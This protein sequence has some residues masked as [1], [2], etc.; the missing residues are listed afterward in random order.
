MSRWNLIWPVALL[1]LLPLAAA[2]Y[3]YP[4]THLP[5]G[6]GVFPPLFVQHPPGFVLWVFILVA[7]LGLAVVAVY[8]LPRLFGIQGGTPASP[9]TP[10]SLPWWFWLGLVLTAFF[11]WLMWGRSPAFGDLMYYAFTPLWTGLILSVDGL[12]YARS[13]GQSLIA[14]RPRTMLFAILVSVFGWS[15]FEYFNYFIL[16]NW[17]YPNAAPGAMP[18]SHAQV[19][20]LYVIAYATVWPAIFEWYTLLNTF[21]R[22]VVRYSNG[23]RL[24]L[25]GNLLLWAGLLLLVLMVFFPYPLFWGV[26]IGTTAVFA[27]M[28]VRANIP[29]PF[30]DLANGNWG[31]MLL[32]ALSSGIN[33]IFWEMWNYGSAHPQLP[34]ANPNY[35]HYEI[36]YVDIIHLHSEMPLLGYFGY[37]PFGILVWVVFI[38]AGK[39]FR[40]N[41]QL[42]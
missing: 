18:L 8:L 27:A 12:T 28:L 35:W 14:T 30:A 9:A 1:L 25:P 4:T 15:A 17:Y 40:V 10:V 36:P 16:E 33:G 31:P 41:T 39:L 21:P 42:T 20:V 7:L 6:F 22:L 19:V 34:V 29:S 3:A 37:L 5:P 26:W 23:P 13:G 32:M 24:A 11:W 2:W 38:W